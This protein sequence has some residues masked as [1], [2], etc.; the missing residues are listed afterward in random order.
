MKIKVKYHVVLL[1]IAYL[2]FS[3]TFIAKAE[4]NA[5]NVTTKSEFI[6]AVADENIKTIHVMADLD[7][8]NAGVLDVD[9]RT[10]DLNGHTIENVNF[11]LIFQGSN[12][13]I[14]NGNFK[15]IDGNGLSY[16][17]FIG[18]IGTTDNVII[19]NVTMEGG[20]NVFNATNVIL[21]NVDITGMQYYA[22]W[23][24][25]NGHVIVEDGTFKTN[26]V[27]IIGMSLTETD[28]DIKGGNFITNNKPF[29]LVNKDADGN[30]MYNRPVIS[31]GT[32]DV[33]IREYCL[34]DYEMVDNGN[35]SFSVKIKEP[36]KPSKP[37]L[38]PETNV[39]S[40]VKN[41]D[42]VKVYRANINSIPSVLNENSSIH[43]DQDVI[44]KDNEITFPLMLK[45]I[46]DRDT[47]TFS[48]IW[49]LLAVVCVC[50]GIKAI[51]IIKKNR[52]AKIDY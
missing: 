3:G 22:I 29:L 36:I 40:N 15:V 37:I 12:F 14:K 44:D 8:T 1:F 6:A 13:T 31:G 2:F 21:R 48:W 45:V 47:V 25:E 26:G 39:T 41:K 24:D 51:S 16:A 19:E 11:S 18:D 49:M 17:L 34:Q 7:L 33:D 35:G 30:D 28:L 42:E 32:F 50:T 9:G 20:I 10:I 46:G 4:E 52:N 27:A 38:I 5:V 43:E 23:C